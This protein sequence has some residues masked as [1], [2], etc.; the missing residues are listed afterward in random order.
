MDIIQAERLEI[1][2]GFKSWESEMKKI[3]IDYTDVLDFSDWPNEL[4][5]WGEWLKLKRQKK[6]LLAIPF[7]DFVDE[8]ENLLIFNSTDEMKEHLVENESRLGK[9]SR[10][11]HARFGDCWIKNNYPIPVIDGIPCDITPPGSHPG[12]N[13]FWHEPCWPVLA[14]VF[15]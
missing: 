11:G 13:E 4:E 5:N 12:G 3:F 14:P 9:F 10:L 6:L 8:G 1:L 15:M 2:K 7:D